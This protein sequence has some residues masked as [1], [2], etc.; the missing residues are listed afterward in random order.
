M[1]LAR[2]REGMAA[3]RVKEVAWYRGREGNLF[4]DALDKTFAQA[5]EDAERPPPGTPENTIGLGG[6][7]YR[8][9]SRESWEICPETNRMA[10]TWVVTLGVVDFMGCPFCERVHALGI[11]PED[12]GRVVHAWE[13][14]P[15]LFR[16]DYEELV[17]FQMMGVR[18]SRIPRIMNGGHYLGLMV[19]PSKYANPE[20]WNTELDRV[21]SPERNA[22]TRVR[23]RRLPRR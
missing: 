1:H 12:M 16:E 21:N 18:K 14:D 6:P 22:P 10:K 9:P 3:G 15:L 2:L 8:S 13:L 5:K 4:G 19:R 7:Y 17:G 11:R 23:G 20:S